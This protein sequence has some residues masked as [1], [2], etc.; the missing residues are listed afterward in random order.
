MMEQDMYWLSTQWAELLACYAEL[1]GMKALN[2][3][4]QNRGEIIAYNEEA[5]WKKASEFRSIGQ[6]INEAR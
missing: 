3:Y 1:E 6:S 2:I 5:F 4:R